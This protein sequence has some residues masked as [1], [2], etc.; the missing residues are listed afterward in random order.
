MKAGSRFDN[1]KIDFKKQFQIVP[2]LSTTR[3]LSLIFWF[4]VVIASLLTLIPEQANISGVLFWMFVALGVAV[5]IFHLFFPYDKYRPFMFA[6]LILT[7]NSL[8]A[9]LVGLTSHTSRAFLLYIAVIVLISVYYPI[10][11]S[12]ALTAA[13]L[14]FMYIPLI[15]S[16]ARPVSYLKEISYTAPIA[17][18]VCLGVSAMFTFAKQQHSE[19]LEIARLYDIADIKRKELSNLYSMALK[20]ASTLDTEEIADFIEM[21]AGSIIECDGGTLM[22]KG[23]NYG[24]DVIFNWGLAPENP[25]AGNMN[26][27]T[28][29]SKAILPVVV[30]DLKNDL[31]YEEFA[32]T[33][34]QIGSLVSVPLFAS[35]SVIGAMAVFSSKERVYND[36]NVR[37]LLTLGSQVAVAIEK[38][39]LYREIS[40]EKQLVEAI[41]RNLNDGLLVID[42]SGRVVFSNSRA[43]D[44]LC[45]R[46]GNE[47]G[48]HTISDVLLDTY[49][50][51]TDDPENFLYEAITSSDSA[52]SIIEEK[53]RNPHFYQMFTIPFGGK[54]PARTGSL[55]IFH[56]ITELKRIDQLKSD[57]I[58]MVSHELKTPLTSIKGFVSIIMAGKAGIVSPKQEHYLRIAQQQTENLSRIIEDL[59]DLSSIESGA[60]KIRL[61][62]LNIKSIVVNTVE[63][64][65]ER[66]KDRGL[67]VKTAIENGLPPVVGDPDR[68]I[69][70]LTNLLENAIKFT[71]SG[72]LIT[73]NS[74][75]VNE[76]CEIEVTDTGIGIPP[77]ELDQIFSKFYQVDSSS[78]RRKG[79]TGLGLTIT[80]QL[81]EAMGGHIKAVSIEGKGST[82]TFSLPLFEKL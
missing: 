54:S 29:A 17:F 65:E 45:M 71:E 81:V 23:D 43:E 13:T 52:Y 57:F 59:L 25:L 82:F 16:A 53:S 60:L 63:N 1:Q 47:T 61:R 2:I 30:D 26:P 24:S 11:V 48:I 40:E 44:V 42:R 35:S 9:T 64:F 4:T 67:E 66:L 7:T 8:I 19:R 15:A 33:N 55:I 68:L 75:I 58:S 70:V 28:L 21:E 36:D 76:K 41:L 73:I 18:M 79:G 72:G 56:D 51:K 27:I 12:I 34:E 69:Q 20:L 38:A 32:K 39:H 74:Q 78:R 3:F 6:L 80:R 10:S 5:F 37:L 49:E 50:I 46:I 62:P 14:V 77:E 22:I 31:E